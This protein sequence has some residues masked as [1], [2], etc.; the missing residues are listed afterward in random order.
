MFVWF[1]KIEENH[2][3]EEEEPIKDAE[4]RKHLQVLSSRLYD[5]KE[6][7][8]KIV[9]KINGDLTDYTGQLSS[10]EGILIKIFNFYPRRDFS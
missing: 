8:V 4:A 1:F 5:L 7:F 9:H 3:E 10:D 2:D 6:R